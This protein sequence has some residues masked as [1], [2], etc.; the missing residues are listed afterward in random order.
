MPK[1]LSLFAGALSGLLLLLALC[2]L[3]VRGEESTGVITDPAVYFTANLESGG[4]SEAIT[5]MERAL[6][7][8]IN[9][10]SIAIDAAF[11]DFNR[12]SIQE[13]LIAAHDRG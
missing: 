8:R 13:A 6:L 7:D 3:P 4:T 12:Q 1:I 5:P 2:N 10:A 9:A 11:Y